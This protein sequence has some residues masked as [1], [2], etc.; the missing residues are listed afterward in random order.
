MEYIELSISMARESLYCLRRMDAGSPITSDGRK[1]QI[2][3]RVRARAE[4]WGVEHVLVEKIGSASEEQERH[5]YHIYAW[6]QRS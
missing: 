5:K 2:D 4:A 1:E 6:D 3:K